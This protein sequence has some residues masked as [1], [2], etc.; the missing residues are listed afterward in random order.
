M[1]KYL[2]TIT[3]NFNKICSIPEKIRCA[4]PLLLPVV[5]LIIQYNALEQLRTSL[6]LLKGTA[7]FTWVRCKS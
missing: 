3:Q 6:V 4:K 2:F 7:S 1:K 5:D